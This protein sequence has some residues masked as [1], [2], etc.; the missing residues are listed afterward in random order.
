M[1]NRIM[2]RLD[3]EERAYLQG[4]LNAQPYEPVEGFDYYSSEENRKEDYR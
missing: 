4:Y 2:N 1:L 3:D